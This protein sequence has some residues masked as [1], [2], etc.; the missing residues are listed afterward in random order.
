MTEGEKKRIHAPRILIGAVSSGSGKTMITCGI[1]QAFVDRGFQIASFKCGPDYIDPMFHAKVIGTRSNNLDTFFAGES[2]TRYLF[3]KEASGM[4]FSVMEGVMGY[5]DGVGGTTF[6]ASAYDLARTTKTPVVLIVNTKGM[7]LSIAALVKGFAE[8]VPD[9]QIQGV[10]LNQMSAMLYPRI[11]EQIESQTGIHVYGYVPVV[12]EF[13]LESRHL[14]LVLPHEVAALSQKL[15]GLAGIL[16]QTL[17]LDELWKLAQSAEDLDV[18]SPRLPGKIEGVKPR[19]GVAMD[20]AF[21]FYYKDNLELLNKLGAELVEFSPL[22]DA[23]LPLGLNGLLLG[24]GYP[25]LYAKQ[26]SVNQTMRDAIYHAV[27]E[28]NMPCL[29]ECG[30]FMYLHEQMEDM[31]KCSYPMAGVI[32]GKAFCTPKLTRFGYITVSAQQDT[33]CGPAGTTFQAHE[34]HYFDSTACGEAFYAK[35]PIGKR[36]WPC[37]QAGS[38]LLAGFPHLYYYS[39]PKAIAAFLTRCQE[40][41]TESDDTPIRGF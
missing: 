8:F 20:E 33:V 32:A 27:V 11:K 36:G 1:L 6:T 38:N 35:K 15:K 21:C 39:N 18:E 13:V 7:S 29:A 9:S 2:L 17:E 28:Q 10:I 14:G 19:I 4:D 41:R 40:F 24:G 22:R 30:G 5:Y 31:E 34:F 25:E 3:A 12:S 16:E 26:L 37:M 23:E